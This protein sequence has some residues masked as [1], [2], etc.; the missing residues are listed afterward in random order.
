MTFSVIKK[1]KKKTRSIDK[2]LY[3]LYHELENEIFLDQVE[4]NVI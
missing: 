1:K 4:N 3:I 2:V